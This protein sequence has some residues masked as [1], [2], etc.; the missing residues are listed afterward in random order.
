MKQNTP[1]SVTMERNRFAHTNRG[2][3]LHKSGMV[4]R[5]LKRNMKSTFA[6]VVCSLCNPCY[7]ST[8]RNEH[9]FVLTQGCAFIAMMGGGH[10]NNG[11]SLVLM[12]MPFTQLR[13]I[14][15]VCTKANGVAPKSS[16]S[17]REREKRTSNVPVRPR[18]D[19]ENNASFAPRLVLY[20]RCTGFLLWCFPNCPR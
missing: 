7:G 2:V 8:T 1:G 18:L 9:T 3:P 11:Y 5:S 13:G 15:H 19:Q 10:Q 6:H 17:T 20:L 16:G 4:P 12:L 14:H